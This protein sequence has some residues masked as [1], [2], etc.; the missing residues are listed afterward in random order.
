MYKIWTG[1]SITANYFEQIIY[2]YYYCYYIL[3]EDQR[4]VCSSRDGYACIGTYIYILATLG[5]YIFI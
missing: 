5:T 1:A 2:Y 4:R 3:E